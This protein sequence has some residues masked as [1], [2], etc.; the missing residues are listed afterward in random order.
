MVNA[1]DIKK[2]ELKNKIVELFRENALK[3]CQRNVDAARELG[4]QFQPMVPERDFLRFGSDISMLFEKE[5][6]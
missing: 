4:F 6:L 2:I 3:A 1:E 5:K